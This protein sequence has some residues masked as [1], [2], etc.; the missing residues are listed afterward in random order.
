MAK[1]AVC[2]AYLGALASD[3]D[4]VDVAA[5]AEI[6]EDARAYGLM[7]EILRFLLLRVSRQ[8]ARRSE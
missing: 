2:L 3:D 5:R 6:V 4:E 7:H 8:A 1:Y